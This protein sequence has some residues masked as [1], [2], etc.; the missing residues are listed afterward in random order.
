MKQR[1]YRGEWERK[2]VVASVW[3]EDSGLP[4]GLRDSLP[5]IR[6]LRKTI[7]EVPNKKKL[8]EHEGMFGEMKMF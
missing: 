6:H 8:K 3:N 5:G 4:G 2:A 1:N 7:W